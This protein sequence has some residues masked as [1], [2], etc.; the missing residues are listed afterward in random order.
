M[1]LLPAPALANRYRGS[2][3]QV[4]VLAV[5]DERLAYPLDAE[6]GVEARGPLRSEAGL[7]LGPG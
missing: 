7:G 5:R 4:P 6:L 2:E 1:Q 3:V